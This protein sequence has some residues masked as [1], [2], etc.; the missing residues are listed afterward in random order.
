MRRLSFSKPPPLVVP[1]PPWQTPRF[2]YMFG[3]PIET[4][5]VGPDDKEAC[6]RVYADVS[7]FFLCV[8]FVFVI[9]RDDLKTVRVYTP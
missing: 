6:A 2:Y 4:G 8:L 9:S 5:D 3:K 1:N 7:A